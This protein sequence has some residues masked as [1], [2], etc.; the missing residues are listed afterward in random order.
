MDLEVVGRHTLLFDDDTTSAFVNSLEAL[1]PWIHDSSLLIDRYDV[2][3]LLDRIPSRK[4]YPR[5]APQDP[6]QS[7]LDLE[8]YLDLPPDHQAGDGG[9]DSHRNDASTEAKKGSE[10]AAHGAYQ[11]VPLSYGDIVLSV[12]PVISDSGIS[13]SGFRPHFPLPDSLLTNL[14]PTEKLHQIISR[15]ALFVSEHGGQSEIILRVKQGNNPTFGF[16]MPDHHLH[17]YYRFLV[18]HP[19]LL[20]ADDSSKSQKEISSDNEGNET[21]VPA[22][23]ALSLLGSVYGSGE[24]DDIALQA[25]TDQMEIHISSVAAS[26]RTGPS[27]SL[28]SKDKVASK[29]Q[30]A[31]TVKDKTFTSRKKSSVNTASSSDGSNKKTKD[32][33][34]THDSIFRPWVPETDMSSNKHLILEPPSLLK[35][36]ID[37]IVE[38]I[39]RNGKD[40]EAVL[41]EQD[42]A[43]GKF[44]FL[45]PTN[46][47]HPYYLKVLQGASESSAQGN[48]GKA[49]VGSNKDGPAADRQSTGYKV[50]SSEELEGWS[51]DPMRKEKFKMVIGAPKKDANDQD[52]KSVKPS[53]VT[54]DEAAA[55]VLAATRGTSPAN[56]LST[57]HM[58]HMGATGNSS[59]SSLNADGLVSKSVSTNNS[60]AV[61]SSTGQ[62][63]SGQFPKFDGSDV[64]KTIA[65]SAAL[66]AS[67][68]ADSSEV[69]L[70]KEQKLKAERLKRA[71]IFAAMIKSGQEPIT[72][73]IQAPTV[74]SG[75]LGPTTTPSSYSGVESDHEPR[76]REGSCV[77]NNSEI[78][79]GKKSCRRD[80]ASDHD[81]EH[82]SQRKRSSRSRGNESDVE[83]DHRHSRKKHHSECSHHGRDT[84]KHH[85]RHSSKESKHHRHHHDSSEDEHRHRKKST[86]RRRH[87]SNELSSDVEDHERKHSDS[88][89]RR[90]S[91]T[92]PQT[93][94][95][96]ENEKIINHSD[97]AH[98]SLLNKPK[99]ET[100]GSDVQ[101]PVATEIP[102]ELRA[103]IR[104]MLL[105][106]L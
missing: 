29:N 56:F 86:S 98:E 91:H 15:T 38:F 106:I 46:Q 101:P 75:S 14:P 32:D 20:K 97:E 57:K 87:K 16:L 30:A 63:G 52:P 65:K 10:F 94:G 59:F 2:R 60:L 89:H 88:S 79:D 76:E 26:E 31:L 90:I 51:Y 5:A 12:E 40:F 13:C 24:D 9:D 8:R 11:A 1:V 61:T 7:E 6:S 78:L 4:L 62:L 41:I 96:V 99:G 45:L 84:H 27:V 70:S 73:L 66:A 93:K 50:N 54:P 100:E 44:P 47:Y 37:K 83:K 49:H 34:T 64:A 81:R 28:A 55:I 39:R 17:P 53:G 21:Q 25:D 92:H 102:S 71:K 42:K 35:R 58:N 80:S 82:K 22:T 3:H 85:K 103:K 67:N 77:P 95:L 104:N 43:N 33:S 68:E 18:D 48:S 19:E 36:V 23:G 69:S 105:E 74:R 72:E